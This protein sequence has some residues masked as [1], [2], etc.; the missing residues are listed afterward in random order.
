MQLTYSYL[1]AVDRCQHSKNTGRKYETTG[2]KR[3][4]NSCTDRETTDSQLCPL[5]KPSEVKR[6]QM[7]VGAFVCAGLSSHA[8]QAS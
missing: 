1:T 2:D 8:H 5:I 6:D 7:R 4:P 3:F